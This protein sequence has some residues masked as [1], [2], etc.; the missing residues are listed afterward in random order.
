LQAFFGTTLDGVWNAGRYDAALPS[1]GPGAVNGPGLAYLGVGVLVVAAGSL[2]LL[3]RRRSAWVMALVAIVSAVL[4]W[5]AILQLTAGHVVSLPWLPWQSLMNLPALDDILPLHF[6]AMC[7]LALAL[8]V[9]MGFDAARHWRG[10]RVVVVPVRQ[11]GRRPWLVSRL[12]AMASRTRMLAPRVPALALGVL[13]ILML[14]PL[15]RTY[16]V[17]LTVESA[18]LPPW[19]ATEANDIPAGSVVLSYPF[20]ASGSLTSA[21]MVWQA[22]DGMRFRLAG[23]YAKVPGPDGTAIDNGPPGS[24]VRFLTDL[25]LPRNSKVTRLLPD[26]RELAALRSAI[27]RWDVGYVVVANTGQHPVVAAAVFTAALGV[28]PRVS[29]RAWV[30]DLVRHGRGG[31]GAPAASASVSPSASVAALQS[32]GIWASTGLVHPRQPLPQ[33]V[34]RCI[35]G[36]LG[37]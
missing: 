10:W 3:W 14:W 19:Y 22:V 11:L 30:W 13:S 27:R 20:P 7:D 21:P 9:A 8:L 23:G 31:G 2:A 37:T 16:Q 36:A 4:S 12:P 18:D 32:C 26:S 5:G 15:W 28:M 6:A 1:L 35:V 24:A 33:D 29:H 34:N 25:S 17:P